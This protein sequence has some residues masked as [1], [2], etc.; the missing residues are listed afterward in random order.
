MTLRDWQTLLNEASGRNKP[1]SEKTLKNL[2][3]LIMAI[4]KFGYQ[5]YQCELLSAK[6]EAEAMPAETVEA[7]EE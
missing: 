5:D 6:A 4:V 2:R 1:L 7:I 3:A